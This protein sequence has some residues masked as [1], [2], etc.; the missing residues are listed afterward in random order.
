MNDNRGNVTK[1]ID[2]IGRKI[3]LEYN[4]EGLL[5]WI[6]VNGVRAITY[7]FERVND[8]SK[9]PNDILL[10]DDEYILTV[11]NGTEESEDKC[12]Y[13]HSLMQQ[14]QNVG[15]L[16]EDGEIVN[17]TRTAW[18]MLLNEVDLGNG[19]KKCYEYDIVNVHFHTDE[20]TTERAKVKSFY[21]QNGSKQENLI[22]YTY[23]N[24]D[25]GISCLPQTYTHSTTSVK[26]GVKTKDTYNN[27]QYLTET[28]QLANRTLTQTKYTI[29]KG[30]FKDNL[31]YRTE[32]RQITSSNIDAEV[33]ENIIPYVTYNMYTGELDKL[34][35]K[36]EGGAIQYWQYDYT[37]YYQ[38]KRTY[39][40]MERYAS[41]I[42]YRISSDGKTVDNEQAYYGGVLEY[43]K[44]FEYNENGE[45]T[46]EYYTSENGETQ[47]TYNY[48][49]FTNADNNPEKNTLIVT[50]TDVGVAGV[51]TSNGTNVVESTTYDLFG[52]PVK[53]IDGNGTVHTLEY[54][55]SGDLVRK[56]NTTANTTESY[57]YDYLTNTITVTDI[58][59]NMTKQCYDALGR[60]VKG[61]V[62]KPETGWLVT[63]TAEYDEFGRLA[64]VKKNCNEQ[65]TV[66]DVVTYTY[67]GVGRILSE[68]GK[69]GNTIFSITNYSYALAQ[70]PDE[71]GTHNGTQVIVTQYDN[72]VPY[73]TVKLYN[74]KGLLVEET[75]PNG[76]VQTYTYTDQNLP[77]DI[78]KDGVR[79]VSYQYS[80][81]DRLWREYDANGKYIQYDYDKYGNVAL[82]TDKMGN[83]QNCIY[84]SRGNL[85]YEFHSINDDVRSETGH[86]YDG[87]GN[88]IYTATATNA[89]SSEDATYTDT[90]YTYDANNNLLST[91]V[92]GQEDS[93]STTY[94]YDTAGRMLTQTIGAGEGSATTTYADYNYQNLPATVTDPMGNITSYTYNFDGTVN[95][96][97]T[98]GITTN[99]SYTA[100]G[101]LAEKSVGNLT[102]SYV[103]DMMN[104]VK[105]VTEKKNGETV[106]A[107]DYTHD[108]MGNVTKEIVDGVEKNYTYDKN[109]NRVSFT[110]D[111]INQTYVYDNL[112]RLTEVKENGNT[113]ANYRYNKNGKITNAMFANGI[114]TDYDYNKAGW[115]INIK[116]S[117]D[118]SVLSDISYLYSR[119][120][121]ILTETDKLLEKKVTYT[122]DGLNRLK[123]ETDELNNRTYS[124]NYDIRGNRTSAVTTDSTGTYNLSYVYDL[125]NKLLQSTKTNESG[126]ELELTEYTYDIRGNMT[127]KAIS[128]GY[129]QPEYWE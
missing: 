1:I 51:T 97:T 14:V 56:T 38:V 27:E 61:E 96:E 115:L 81:L 85:I 6:D 129:E 103:Y 21:V 122:Y 29:G 120:G 7:S 32:Q 119:D 90:A 17:L 11:Y 94:T 66:S 100:G 128:P 43:E 110:T 63:D 123:T 47:Y 107:V 16:N 52:R 62:Y 124:Y 98:N 2:S 46:K 75:L 23:D 76:S 9:D 10:A 22:T 35:T 24:P 116:T 89:I 30:N 88:L 105:R 36:A 80:F 113:I 65:G 71:E 74:N 57:D 111:G 114:E 117:N 18:T 31:V 109:G 44:N 5:T 72:S 118:S 48:L 78:T 37:N 93:L 20:Y 106:S 3:D 101:K 8:E 64:A 99:Y 127:S 50:K 13:K 92:S 79:Q 86:T 54:N 73:Q 87:V 39:W 55:T 19:I 60:Y 69:R 12:V 41:E 68:T 126:T 112:N 34:Y 125:N 121:N 70:I 42:I 91:L 102:T 45:L 49:D 84:N 67:D 83:T 28:R 58:A 108:F 40:N 15:N 104:N 33:D 25:E 77:E 4:D 59:G 95:N 53:Q 26:N 82:I